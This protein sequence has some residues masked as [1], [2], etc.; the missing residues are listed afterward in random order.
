MQL[1]LGVCVVV[2][3][4]LWSVLGVCAVYNKKSGQ[5]HGLIWEEK[6]RSIIPSQNFESEQSTTP[7]QLLEISL[8]D[9]APARKKL[10]SL[11]ICEV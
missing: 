4:G 11:L 6:L 10:V 3:K 7:S 5:S 8:Q 1:V 2:L 9:D